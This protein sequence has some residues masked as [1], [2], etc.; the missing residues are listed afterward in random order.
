MDLKTLYRRGSNT[1][2]NPDP[3]DPDPVRDLE[4]YTG[5]MICLCVK[6]MYLNISCPFRIVVQYAKYVN[7][8]SKFLK[9]QNSSTTNNSQISRPEFSY[10][11]GIAEQILWNIICSEQSF[12]RIP[13][14]SAQKFGF[15]GDV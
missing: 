8:I 6:F 1:D 4:S 5:K 3:P 12:T 7:M 9:S 14:F 10:L 11:F 13:P 2:A 15:K